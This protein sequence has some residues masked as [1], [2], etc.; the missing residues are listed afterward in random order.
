V[1]KDIPKLRIDDAVR[2]RISYDDATRFGGALSGKI[3]EV[4]R[5]G[6]RHIIEAR[7]HQPMSTLVA[8]SRA[9]LATGFGPAALGELYGRP[10][11]LREECLYPS[12][13]LVQPVQLLVEA[14][15]KVRAFPLSAGLASDLARWMGEWSR[16]SGAPGAGDARSLWEGLHDG[17]FLVDCA[18][19][20]K[21]PE[22][23]SVTFLGHASIVHRVAST[24]IVIDP[25]LLPRSDRYPATYQPITAAELD[26]VDG[27]LITHSH[28]DHFDLGSLLRF[29][30]DT[31]IY[32]PAVERES[33]LAIDM[34]AR[35]E[36]LGFSRVNRLR[37]FDEVKLGSMHVVALPFYGEQPTA[38]QRYHPELRN[39]GNTY[40]IRDADTSAAYIADAGADICGNIKRV[41]AEAQQ[42]FGAI[43]VL[44]GT[45]R[46]FPVYPIQYLFSSVSRYLLFV[47][48]QSWT[49]RQQ[50]M[51]NA[52]DLLDTAEE[53]GARHVVPYACGGAPWYWEMGL[54][55]RPP[56]VG[57][58]SQ[59]TDPPPE[60]VRDAQHA[61]TETREGMI[62]SPVAVR[63]MRPGESIDPKAGA[64]ATE[65][66][67]EWPYGELRRA[68]A[69]IEKDPELL[70]RGGE[71]LA[72]VRKKILL[73]I[74]AGAE[75][76][77]HDVG[78]SAAE[79][80][81]MADTFRIRYGL[82]TQRDV[83]QWLA[84]ESLDIGSF[85]ATM[86]E[87]V[88]VEKL[89]E[90]FAPQI[91]EALGVALRINTARD[92]ISAKRR[93]A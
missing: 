60:E 14:A 35:L 7:E 47:P 76:E 3:D 34:A 13:D 27:V 39:A 10:G 21:A 58:R 84:A 45:H 81:A 12:A 93:T 24:S 86:R 73:Q 18:A 61:R 59:L 49:S 26:P 91:D 46:G 42:R 80:Q 38:G 36:Q 19:P 33:I 16:G 67:H 8:D 50:I 82:L 31:P 6:C 51:N 64:I 90:R 87:F 72:V 70:L 2:C 5:H 88:L 20:A 29:G 15:G 74:L 75:A 54:G 44:F 41:A 32:V 62:P 4:V 69:D 17:G 83:E 68:A 40:L 78:A 85:A 11:E 37:W 22:R 92:F 65:A 57:K 28:A 56:A 77:R 9:L 23:K 30:A 71:D 53:W 25:F 1:T 89:C 55:P 43:D 52:H 66:S 48:P 63:V 79:I